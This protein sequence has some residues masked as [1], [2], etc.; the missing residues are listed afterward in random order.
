[1]WPVASAGRLARTRT[2]SNSI[3][4]G[5]VA[6]I[7][8]RILGANRLVVQKSSKSGNV[9]CTVISRVSTS[10]SPAR[11]HNSRSTSIRDASR[12]GGF[13]TVSPHCTHFDT[14]RVQRKSTAQHVPYVG[15]HHA[16][17]ANHPGHLSDPFDWLGN[18]RDHQ[19]HCGHIKLI[20][21]ERE[22]HCVPK[23]ELCL[24]RGEPLACK[25]ELGLRRVNAIN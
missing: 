7:T 11:V 12:L 25:V 19:C 21:R 23:I 8:D 18:E 9:L 14:D 5:A 4:S 10:L 6:A 20:C 1:M 15:G 3:S 13:T 2:F 22:C 16:A 24:T 17:R